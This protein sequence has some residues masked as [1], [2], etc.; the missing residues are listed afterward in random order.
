MNTIF[1]KKQLHFI[2]ECSTNILKNLN[3]EFDILVEGFSNPKLSPKEEIIFDELQIDF[4]KLI[5]L[6]KKSEESSDKDA[7][8]NNLNIIKIDLIELSEIQTSESN[9]LTSMLKNPKK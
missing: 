3:D 1:Y 8:I 7:F 4:D 9:H 2:D 5:L 6:E